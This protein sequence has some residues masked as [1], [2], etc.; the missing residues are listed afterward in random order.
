MSEW[1]QNIIG[2]I[3]NLGQNNWAGK[4]AVPLM[5]GRGFDAEDLE[6]F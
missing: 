1:L 5:A 6:L 3:N 4:C 2:I